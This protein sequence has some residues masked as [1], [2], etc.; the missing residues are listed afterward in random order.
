MWAEHCKA[1][2]FCD[3][4]WW[5]VEPPNTVT[6]EGGFGNMSHFKH[7][8][9]MLIKVE[10]VFKEFVCRILRPLL[11]ESH[12]DKPMSLFGWKAITL[13]VFFQLWEETSAPNRKSM[14]AC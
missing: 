9:N 5:G 10:L 3:S 14:Q 11:V 6:G 13:Q 12:A 4:D 1:G 7:R 2:S 8:Y